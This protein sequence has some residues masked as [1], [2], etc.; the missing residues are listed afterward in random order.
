MNKVTI[1]IDQ[2]TC[3]A[4]PGKLTC[5]TSSLCHPSKRLVYI[6]EKLLASNCETRKWHHIVTSITNIKVSHFGTKVKYKL[7]LKLFALWY[8]VRVALILIAI[9][10]WYKLVSKCKSYF[11]I[12]TNFTKFWY[13]LISKFTCVLVLNKSYFG[14]GI[15]SSDFWYEL[16]F[17]LVPST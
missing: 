16:I 9:K 11:S 12:G 2:L 7:I 17:T 6:R 1:L 15:N 13:Q 3:V 14:I 4:P 8:Q 5:V 10:L